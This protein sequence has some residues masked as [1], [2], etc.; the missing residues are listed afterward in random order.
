LGVISGIGFEG[1]AAPNWPNWPNRQNRQ[2]RQNRESLRAGCRIG[3]A[4]SGLRRI[5]GLEGIDVVP[6]RMAGRRVESARRGSD[7]AGEEQL[8]VAMMKSRNR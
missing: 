8:A 6:V 3:A 5:A 2:N 1:E 4:D 7:A